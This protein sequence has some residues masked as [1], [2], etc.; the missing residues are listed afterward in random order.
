MWRCGLDSTDSVF[1]PVVGLHINDIEHS[2]SGFRHVVSCLV[3]EGVRFGA[4]APS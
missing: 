4:A 2:G 3:D 1:Y